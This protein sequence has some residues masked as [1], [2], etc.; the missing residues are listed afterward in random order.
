MAV[1]ANPQFI[2]GKGY[3]VLARALNVRVYIAAKGLGVQ[4]KAPVVTCL[5]PLHSSQPPRFWQ[6]IT[7]SNQEPLVYAGNTLETESKMECQLGIFIFCGS[8]RSLPAN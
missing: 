3:T 6:D 2:T 8:W 1:L 5:T 7:L 4:V